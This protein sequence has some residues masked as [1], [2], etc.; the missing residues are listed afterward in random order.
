MLK[1]LWH[2]YRGYL[3]GREPLLT[4]AYFCLTVLEITAGGR[5]QAAAMYNISKSVLNTLAI[6]ASERGDYRTARKIVSSTMQPL[7]EAETAWIQETIKQIILRV[8]DK[9][10]VLGLPK[11]T[12]AELPRL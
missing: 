3:E 1:S 12:M 11:I 2:R 6:L 5:Q 4:M 8:G 10:S 9:R 7:S